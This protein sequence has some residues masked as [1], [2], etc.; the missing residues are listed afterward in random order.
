MFYEAI[1]HFDIRTAALYKVYISK[2]MKE[3]GALPVAMMRDIL[4]KKFYLKCIFR[5]FINALSQ[6]PNIVGETYSN[7]YADISA[8]TFRLI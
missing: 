2:G 5:L 7:D 3:L 4:S 8:N 6:T 1:N